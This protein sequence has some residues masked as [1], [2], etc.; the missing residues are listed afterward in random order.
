MAGDEATTQALGQITQT[1]GQ[2]RDTQVEHGKT[3]A[4]LEERSKQHEKRMNRT[5]KRSA[6]IAGAV[7]AVLIGAKMWL[8]GD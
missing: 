3:L 2:I 8:T 7:S 4:T 1:L 5:D 6:G